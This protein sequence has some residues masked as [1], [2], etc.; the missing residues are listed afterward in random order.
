MKQSSAATAIKLDDSLTLP[1]AVNASG[2]LN[3]S[4]KKSAKNQNATAESPQIGN[5]LGDI[6]E[7]AVVDSHPMAGTNLNEDRILSSKIKPKHA[8]TVYHQDVVSRNI[9]IAAQSVQNRCME[10]FRLAR[11]LK[12]GKLT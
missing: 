5:I 8:S 3:K 11:R 12:D 7:S 9:A 10:M 6:N 1:G 2:N 4:L